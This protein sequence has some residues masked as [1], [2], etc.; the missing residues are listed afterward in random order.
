MRRWSAPVDEDGVERPIEI[1]P[2]GDPDRF[3]R[4]D[5]VEHL[6]RPDRQPGGAQ[7]TGEMHQI[8]DEP[9]VLPRAS[10]PR[11]IPSRRLHH[12]V[13]SAATTR[14]TRSLRRLTFPDASSTTSPTLS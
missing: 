6:A 8:G 9:P 3:D 14:C 13:I 12:S 4:G 7:G 2:V 10:C 1:A 5:R 11:A